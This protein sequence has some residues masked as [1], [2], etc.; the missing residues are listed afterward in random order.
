LH[1]PRLR[2]VLTKVVYDSVGVPLIGE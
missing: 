1:W 2:D